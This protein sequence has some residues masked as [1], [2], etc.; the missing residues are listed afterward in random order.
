MRKTQR[1]GRKFRE[2]HKE[3]SDKKV[4]SEQE[5]NEVRNE[6]KTRGGTRR[7]LRENRD[8]DFTRNEKSTKCGAR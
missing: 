4:R 6:K 7:R 5:E 8:E 3:M 1:G 2:K